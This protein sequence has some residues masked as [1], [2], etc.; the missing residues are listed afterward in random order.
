[1][2]ED[3]NLV[4]PVVKGL[5]DQVNIVGNGSGPPALPGSCITVTT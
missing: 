4:V 2:P 3:E 1:M 5:T